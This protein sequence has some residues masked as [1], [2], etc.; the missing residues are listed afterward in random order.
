MKITIGSALDR[1]EGEVREISKTETVR[2]HLDG[3]REEIEVGFDSASGDIQ[4][5]SCGNH[6]SPI[7]VQ[8][9]AT[10]LVSINVRERN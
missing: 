6:S 9:H 5:R 1:M 4:I 7:M 10:N 3:G 8:P 2:F